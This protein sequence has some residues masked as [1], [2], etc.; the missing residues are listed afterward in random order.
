[1]VNLPNLESADSP[2]NKVASMLWTTEAS[3][4]LITLLPIFIFFRFILVPSEIFPVAS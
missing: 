2:S 3:T 4:L 1:M